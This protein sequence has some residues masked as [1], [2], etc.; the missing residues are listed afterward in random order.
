MFEGRDVLGCRR[1]EVLASSI[2]RYVLLPYEAARA[3]TSSSKEFI[4]KGF[5]GTYKCLLVEPAD[6]HIAIPQERLEESSGKKLSNCRYVTIV[7]H[8]RLCGTA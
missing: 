5:Y 4:P 6:M 3:T 7:V 8:C 1:S 2:Y